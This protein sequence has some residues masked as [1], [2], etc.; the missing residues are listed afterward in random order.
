[1]TENEIAR[2]KL[3]NIL[4]TRPDL[5]IM[6]L[7]DEHE[8]VA[9]DCHVSWLG[10]VDDVFIADVWTGQRR[11]YFMDEALENIVDFID[12][13]FPN[14]AIGDVFDLTDEQLIKWMEKAGK[15]VEELPWKRVIVLSVTTPDRLGDDEE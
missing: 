5:P 9:Y 8:V 3:I 7:I 1:M 15:F 13:E 2:N 14:M 11:M 4:Q 10:D 12:S 6:V